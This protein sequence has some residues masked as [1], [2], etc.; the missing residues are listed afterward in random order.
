M[1]SQYPGTEIHGGTF[2]FKSHYPQLHMPAIRV[3]DMDQ[4]DPSK[5]KCLLDGELV[6]VGAGSDSEAPGSRRLVEVAAGNTFTAAAGVMSGGTGANRLA[7]V[8]MR[9]GRG[10]IQIFG[11]VPCVQDEPF[12]FLTRL[13]NT[14]ATYSLG[15]Q[16]IASLIPNDKLPAK[17]IAMT[18]RAVAGLVPVA[19]VLSDATLDASENG[20]SVDFHATVTGIEDTNGWV[21]CRWNPGR[22]VLSGMAD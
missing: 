17:V 19:F 22:H 11:A 9:K 2:Q 7:P 15:S 16:L 13:I 5:A 12:E 1:I 4:V 18:S 20:K 14:D 6:L 3:A 10:D 8:H 21:R